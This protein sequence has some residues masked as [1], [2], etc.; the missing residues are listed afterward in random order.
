MKYQTPL[1]MPGGANEL[2]AKIPPAIIGI[3]RK[4]PNRDCFAAISWSLKQLSFHKC[5]L[6]NKLWSWKTPT[7]IEEIKQGHAPP[8]GDGGQLQL[9]YERGEDRIPRDSATGCGQ[10]GA[11][12]AA[13]GG[14]GDD[15][16]MD[17][18]AIADGGAGPTG[19]VK[20]IV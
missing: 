17:R 14:D 8:F 16:E 19:F 4:T 1:M 20:Q 13:A 11:G 9:T 18:G 3:A 5:P 6:C 15:S 7:F 2:I 10:G 12:S